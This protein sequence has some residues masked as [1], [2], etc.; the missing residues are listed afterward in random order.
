MLERL[1]GH[2]ASGPPKEAT[3]NATP[4]TSDLRLQA[5][6]R[7]EDPPH[8]RQAHDQEEDR[9]AEAQGDAHVGDAVEAPAEAADQV[10]DGVEQGDRLPERGQH[11]HRVE[12][13]RKS[14]RLNSSHANISYA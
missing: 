2:E 3:Y 8:R 14:T 5:V 12:G 13:D 6:T 9:H 1:E 7:L 11:V 10:H 4:E